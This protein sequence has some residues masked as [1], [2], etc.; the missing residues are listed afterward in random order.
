M[1]KPLML[2][3]YTILL[4][5]CNSCKHSENSENK[6]TN[7]RLTRGYPA[8]EK[9]SIVQDDLGS[10]QNFTCTGTWVSKNTMLTAAHCVNELGRNGKV[11][12]NGRVAHTVLINDYYSLDDFF[13]I[14]KYDLAVLIFGTRSQREFVSVSSKA[15]KNTQSFEIV[16]FGHTAKASWDEINERCSGKSTESAARKCEQNVMGKGDGRKYFGENNADYVDDMIYFSGVLKKGEVLPGRDVLSG[17]GDSGGPMLV[18]GEIVGVTSGG[19]PSTSMYVNLHSESSQRLLKKALL[20]GARISGFGREYEQ[21]VITSDFNFSPQFTGDDEISDGSWPVNYKLDISATKEVLRK[22]V[23]IKSK[24][25][26]GGSAQSETLNAV[27]DDTNETFEVPDLKTF[28]PSFYIDDLIL[29]LD[30]GRHLNVPAFKVNL[31]EH[32][33]SSVLGVDSFE[34]RQNVE[35]ENTI[36]FRKWYQVVLALKGEALALDKVQSVKYHVTGGPEGFKVLESSNRSDG[37]KSAS[38]TSP[39]EEIDIK[40]TEIKLIDGRIIV[41]R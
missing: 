21:P 28:Y 19:F 7:G 34:V 32:F 41:I 2:A 18:D 6:I 37:F 20:A 16:G 4:L 9:I 24:S 10:L 35:S 33:N 12:V 5:V 11:R 14:N 26:L 3:F 36:N 15:I 31:R 17:S 1:K 29:E 38:E 39:I 8:V 23:S 30:D 25:K 13:G 40:K 27:L 22:V